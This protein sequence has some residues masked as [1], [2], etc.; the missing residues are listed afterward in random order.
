V[1]WVNKTEKKKE[2]KKNKKKKYIISTNSILLLLLLQ[3][4]LKPS[5]GF[6]LLYDLIPR[7]SIFTLL[8]PIAHIHLL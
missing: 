4:A 6:G 5:V 8:S 1:F 3:S 2:G 7:S